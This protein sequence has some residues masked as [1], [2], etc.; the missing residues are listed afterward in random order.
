MIAPLE[1]LYQD[2]WIVAVNKPAG[3]MVHPA[4]IP[5]EGD[6]V[7]MKIL[8]DQI[9]K[10]VH[11]IHRLDRP[12]CG[13]LL[14]GIDIHISK[15]LH[16]DFEERRVS[17]MYHAVVEGEPKKQ[18]WICRE[19]IQKKEGVAWKEAETH[20]KVIKQVRNKDLSLTLIQAVPHTGR[21]HQIRKHLLVEGLPIVGDYR[22]AGI[23]RSNELAELL[24]TEQR[25]FLQARSLEFIHPV[26]EKKIKIEAPQ[27]PLFEKIMKMA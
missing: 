1:I 8:R 4:D 18:D 19:A 22:Y 11:T 14:F 20:F 5:Q 3:Q 10:Q 21:Y 17:K 7:T 12:T 16:R 26:L 13:V 23:E 24:Q 15:S 6:L 2:E 27:E 25:M 9:K